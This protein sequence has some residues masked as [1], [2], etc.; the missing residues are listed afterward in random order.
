MVASAGRSYFPCRGFQSPATRHMLPERI[1]FIG[2]GGIGV[3]AL[4]QVAQARGCRVS[5]SDPNANAETNPAVA[6]L[7][8]GGATIFREHHAE[9]VPDATELVVATAA[10]KDDNPE[11]AEARRRG[12]RVVSR[13]DFLGELMA[14]HKGPKIA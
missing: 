6:R 5:G 11:I 10:V 9:N 8:A 1:H 14:A 12:I 4:A 7:L 3:S 13:A 2:I